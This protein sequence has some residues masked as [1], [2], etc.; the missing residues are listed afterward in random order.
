MLSYLGL[1]K[2]SR[3]PLHF[4]NSFHIHESISKQLRKNKNLWLHY[5]EYIETLFW[6]T[7]IQ[8]NVKT[9]L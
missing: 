6:R 9:T 4:S 5:E 3:K 1:A 7:S 2:H 8:P